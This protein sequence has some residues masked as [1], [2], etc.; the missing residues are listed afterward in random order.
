MKWVGMAAGT[1]V[2]LGIL[3]TAW[4]F[5][6]V[7]DEQAAAQAPSTVQQTVNVSGEGR[8]AA[9]P[10]LAL[11]SL[12][13]TAR[14]GTVAEAMDQA[15]Q[16]IDKV[17]DTLRANG[18]DERDIQTTSISISPQF[19]RPPGPD[20]GPPPITGYL[21][22]QQLQV[23]VR[24]IG[25]AGKVIDDAAAAGGDRFQ[26]Q[27]LRFAFADPS[28]LQSQ[29][30]EQALTRAKAKAEELARLGGLTLGAPI[31]IN[32][33][34]QPPTPIT[35]AAVGGD[36]AALPTPAPTGI[37]PGELEVVVTVQVSYSAR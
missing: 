17:R 7:V 37:S 32:E 6:S 10:D 25:R 14:A 33:G 31:A 18:I 5:H 22:S 21:A 28:G 23:K 26:M 16:A 4:P 3:L 19:G 24:D 13:V 8:A 29:A 2:L 15:N 36:V 27:G 30:R 20:G 9:R 12:G 1:I 11:L 35:R 34:A